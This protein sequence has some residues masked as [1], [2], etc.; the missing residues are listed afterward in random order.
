MQIKINNINFYTGN[1]TARNAHP[2]VN[3]PVCST[4]I[5]ELPKYYYQP[6][7]TSKKE[8]SDEEFENRLIKIIQ[9]LLKFQTIP[10]EKITQV[11][12]AINKNNIHIAE[13]F[14][15]DDY[16][17]RTGDYE[18]LLTHI[19]DENNDFAEKILFDKSYNMRGLR[20]AEYIISSVNRNNAEFAEMI[21]KE[22][23]IP[24]I[25]ISEILSTLKNENCIKLAKAIYDNAPQSLINSDIMLKYSTDPLAGLAEIAKEEVLL[26]KDFLEEIWEIA[27]DGIPNEDINIFKEIKND[28]TCTKGIKVEFLS[29]IYKF[30]FP[31]IKHLYQ[32]SSSTIAISANLDNYYRRRKFFADENLEELM[33]KAD[34]QRIRHYEKLQEDKEKE[35]SEKQGTLT[36]SQTPNNAKSLNVTSILEYKY[37]ELLIATAIFPKETMDII[38]NPQKRYC[39]GFLEKLSELSNDDLLLIKKLARCKK[40]DGKQLKPQD[41]AAL[42]A[43]IDAYN[44]NSKLKSNMLHMAESGTIDIKEL[45]FDLFS[46]IMKQA[47]LNEYEIKNIP[48]KKLTSWDVNYTHSIPELISNPVSSRAIYDTIKAAN[49][50]NFKNYI[51]DFRNIYGDKNKHTEKLYRL[52]GLDYNKWLNIPKELNVTLNQKDYNAERLQQ[53]ARDTEHDMNR[54]RQL[55]PHIKTYIDKRF[56]FCITDDD[57]FKIPDKYSQK[58][59]KLSELIENIIKQLGK[60]WQRAELNNNEALILQNIQNANTADTYSTNEQFTKKVKAIQ[61]YINSNTINTIKDHLYQRLE[62]IYSVNKTPKSKDMNWTIKMW[63]RTPQHDLFQGNYSTCCIALNKAY[64]IYMPYYLLNTAFNMIE[65]NDNNSSETIGNA[66]CYFIIN[67]KAEPTF[68]I[69][70]IEIRNSEQPSND[71]GLLVREAILEYAKRVTKEVTGHDNTRIIL[72]NKYNDIPTADL[73]I[74]DMHLNFIGDI[75]P[76]NI[77]L[78]LYGGLTDKSKLYSA[79]KSVYIFDCPKIKMT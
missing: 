4:Q 78:D 61:K 56:K 55:D 53:I 6:F 34:T 57:K 60:V 13:T 72:G 48:T 71:N 3:K 52:Y 79:N 43:I 8:M 20:Y 58:S 17:F 23:K 36:T 64:G 47:G 7:F 39:A 42:I 33:T 45:E 38:F 24:E 21:C 69:D 50:D 19:N 62:D 37:I 40:P 65:I 29:N 68:V 54:L 27:A 49:F 2:A 75:N 14:A 5:T 16:G 28:K 51:L 9:K 12:N 22:R 15:N 44:K 70:N 11:A 76:D 66:L 41:Y 18:T 35:L 25:E 59:K 73:D 31:I 26:E 1:D 74:E 32:N 77:Y 63:D 67:E 30:N 46:H 10:T